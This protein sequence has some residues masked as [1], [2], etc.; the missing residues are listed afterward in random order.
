MSDLINRLRTDDAPTFD[1][2][3]VYRTRPV[4]LFEEAAEALAQAEARAERAEADLGALR[5]AL[6]VAAKI[7]EGMKG[8]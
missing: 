2:K 3:A 4:S 7:D 5:T 8:T 1:P 6:A